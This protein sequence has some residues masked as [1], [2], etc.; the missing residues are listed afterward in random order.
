MR[1][2]PLSSRVGQE[3]SIRQDGVRY[4]RVAYEIN[5]YPLSWQLTQDPKC[6]ED[7]KEDTCKHFLCI[8]PLYMTLGLENSSENSKAKF[9]IRRTYIRLNN[10]WA[11]WICQQMYLSHNSFNWQPYRR[12]FYSILIWN[13]RTT[14]ELLIS[15]ISCG[16]NKYLSYLFVDWRYTIVLEVIY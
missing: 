5:T 11:T 10:I 9:W 1:V 12:R 2:T 7:V 3:R 13:R 6:V 15:I 16:Y 4:R 8:C 14:N